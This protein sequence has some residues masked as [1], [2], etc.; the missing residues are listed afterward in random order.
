MKEPKK[1]VLYWAPRIISILFALFISMFGFD[2][3]DMGIGFPEII[4]AFFMDML[5]AILVAMMIILAWK[6]ELVGTILCAGLGLFYIFGMNYDMDFVVF[7]LIPM[8]LFILAVLWF[9]A[10][11]QKKKYL[12]KLSV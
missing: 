7:L 8:P 10:W 5:P 2:V 6:W 4:L 1:T 3:F 11:R 12:E 9:L